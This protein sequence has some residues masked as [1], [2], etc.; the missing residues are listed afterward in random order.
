MT[1]ATKDPQRSAKSTTGQASGGFTDQERAAM[2]ERA[3][4][5]KASARGGKVDGE[6]DALAKIAEMPKPDRALAEGL[7]A[8]IK[9][10]VPALSPRTWYGL[11]FHPDESRQEPA[12]G[13]G[14]DCYSEHQ[15]S[16]R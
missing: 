16:I 4:E 12:R 6:T 15:C 2:Q 14:D 9:T 1:P 10:N 8:I 5:L 11:G 13:S 7:H 3:Q